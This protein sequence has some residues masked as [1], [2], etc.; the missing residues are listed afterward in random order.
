MNNDVSRIFGG[1]PLALAAAALIGFSSCSMTNESATAATATSKKGLVTIGLSASTA[2]ARTLFVDYLAVVPA[3]YRLFSSTD[4]LLT[5]LGEWIDISVGEGLPTPTVRLLP[6]TYDFVLDA[7]DSDG[8]E[9]LEGSLND[10]KIS[11]AGTISF[12][13]YGIKTGSGTGTVSLTVEWPS[14]STVSKVTVKLGS[15]DAVDLW[16]E[17]AGGNSVTYTNN[18][19]PVGNQRLLFTLY[20]SSGQVLDTILEVAQVRQNLTATAAT[21]SIASEELNGPPTLPEET[22]I[23]ASSAGSGSAASISWT[24]ASTN[25]AS[26]DLEYST[27]NLAW[28]DLAT[29]DS[30]QTSY[31]DGSIGSEET[32]WYR[33][34]AVNAFGAT[35]YWTSDQFTA[36]H[37]DAT[38]KQLTCS[39]VGGSLYGQSVAI[40]GSYA[41]VGA[42][43]DSAN[44]SAATYAG[45]AYIYERSANGKW[46][47]AATIYAPT[48]KAYQEFGH[49]VAIA[50]DWVFVGDDDS[51]NPGEVSVYS[52]SS[53]SWTYSQTIVAS[54][55]VSGTADRFGSAL[56]ASG[57]KLIVGA[58]ASFDSS[59]GAAYTFSLSGGTWSQSAKLS[60]PEIDMD[61]VEAGTASYR[62]YGGFG[63]PGTVAISDD[64]AVVGAPGTRLSQGE[65]YVYS[66]SVYIYPASSGG[67]GS[68]VELTLASP[69]AF[70]LFGNSIALSGSRIAIG[71]PNRNHVYVY[72]YGSSKD[73][74][75]S[76]TISGYSTGSFGQSVALS[77]NRL[78]IGASSETTDSTECTGAVYLFVYDSSSGWTVSSAVVPS[79][80]QANMRFGS[81]VGLT[82]S[83]IVAGAPNGGAAYVFE[84]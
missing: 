81:S 15:A 36:P 19:A 57:S 74:K 23:S 50:D 84:R 41:I 77:E 60:P 32:R 71:L 39:T 38:E 30:S 46:T 37:S 29:V 2:S 65:T 27:D 40:S 3:K 14:S 7:Y 10:Q 49:S 67:W 73:W 11:E 5:E 17:S 47:L 9:I 21:I 33:V 55:A 12:S 53:G 6:G 54:D 48:P 31:I 63:S 8:K 26:Y 43:Q 45:A 79:S 58:C 75:L 13:L 56:A 51:S 69:T 18:A 66:G 34:R 78:A 70:D 35:E 62:L 1:I 80:A 42:P 4:G 59:S 61:A 82:S 44:S 72:D 16:T 28:G 76:A 24:P 52:R 83:Y 20:D 64:N 68:A 25:T 22:H